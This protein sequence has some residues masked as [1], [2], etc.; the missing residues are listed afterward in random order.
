MRKAQLPNYKNTEELAFTST[1][2]GAVL[3]TALFLDHF[4]F[5]I[6]EKSPVM[7]FLQF[8]ANS[9][10]MHKEEAGATARLAP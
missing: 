8:G 4:S 1:L 10:H 6:A 2:H 5:P 9:G 7:T 3:V